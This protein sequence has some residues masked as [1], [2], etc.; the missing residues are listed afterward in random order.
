MVSETW[1]VCALKLIWR[2]AVFLKLY[3][4]SNWVHKVARLTQ[5]HNVER[6][7]C[8]EREYTHDWHFCLK[9]LIHMPVKPHSVCY[10]AQSA[11]GRKTTSLTIH[12]RIY[13]A[14]AGGSLPF[15]VCRGQ[16]GGELEFFR[17]WCKRW[18]IF[19]FPTNAQPKA[20]NPFCIF[21]SLLWCSCMWWMLS[22]SAA[23]AL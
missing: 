20:E 18:L 15:T 16:D 17:S 11:R 21:K 6:N 3:L 22:S 19:F 5:Y 23:N 4:L 7:I 8:A 14:N 1:T 13:R 9:Q 2:L 10:T 12:C